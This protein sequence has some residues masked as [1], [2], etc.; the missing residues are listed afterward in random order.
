MSEQKNSAVRPTVGRPRSE[1]ATEAVRKA[2]LELAHEGGMANTTIEG[3]AR[4][5]GVAKT[6]IYRRW[7]NA[8]AIVMDAFLHEM[9]PLIAYRR[10][11]TLRQTLAFTL[12]QLVVALQ[13]QRG[14]L[15]KS[16]LGAAQTNPELQLAFQNHWIGPR[17]EQA[18]SVLVE[19]RSSG[20]LAPHVDAD[21]LIDSL[22]G[23]VYYRLMIPYAE[24]S[25][26]FVDRLVEQ[27]FSGAN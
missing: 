12:K 2:A 1:D 19:A 13:G 9:S 24:L 4:K 6:T 16:L 7:P 11:P 15:L 8:S 17:R 22:Y 26:D 25:E 10:R 14:V 27:I 21:L 20:E 3:I 23:A 5:S 18:M